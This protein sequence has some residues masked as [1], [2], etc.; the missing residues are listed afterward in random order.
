MEERMSKKNKKMLCESQVAAVFMSP[1]STSTRVGQL[2]R[3]Q[4][5]TIV[6]MDGEWVRINQ[7]DGWVIK[8]HL[9]DAPAESETQVRS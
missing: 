4:E 7:P 8:G 6:K 2:W 3:G 5:V 1:A 9:V